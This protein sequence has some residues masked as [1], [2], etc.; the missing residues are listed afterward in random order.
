MTS[1]KSSSSTQS[2]LPHDHPARSSLS[3]PV[4]TQSTTHTHVPRTCRSRP[5]ASC[6]VLRLLATDGHILIREPSR[7]P[8]AIPTYRPHSYTINTI[9]SSHSRV[10]VA[11]RS[12]LPRASALVI[13]SRS[14]QAFVSSSGRPWQ[15]NMFRARE[16]A[17]NSSKIRIM[18]PVAVIICN[19][20]ARTL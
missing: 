10:S 17:E 19:M 11:V 5:H 12:Q 15:P 6:L 9:P 2:P 16:T 20:I 4:N 18:C 1:F 13:V 7:R 14:S 8:I 3:R